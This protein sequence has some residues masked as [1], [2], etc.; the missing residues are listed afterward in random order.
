MP[1]DLKIAASNLIRE[2]R[3]LPFPD[4]YQNSSIIFISLE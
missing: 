2:R 3:N 1:R 4:N